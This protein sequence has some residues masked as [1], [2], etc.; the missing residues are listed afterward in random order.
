[1]GRYQF[2][3]LIGWFWVYSHKQRH[4]KEQLF[5]QNWAGQGQLRRWLERHRYRLIGRFFLW[6]WGCF[7]W[8]NWTNWGVWSCL[9]RSLTIRVRFYWFFWQF[10]RRVLWWRFFFRI[11]FGVCLWVGSCDSVTVCTDRDRVFFLTIVTEIVLC[12]GWVFWGWYRVIVTLR[13]RCRPVCYFPR[14]VFCIVVCFS[15]FRGFRMVW[16]SKCSS[17]I[18]YWCLGLGRLFT[19]LMRWQG[20]RILAL[21]SSLCPVSSRL[22]I[23]PTLLSTSPN[24]THSPPSLAHNSALPCF[25]TL[26]PLSVTTLPVAHCYDPSIGY[27]LVVLVSWSHTH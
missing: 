23:F 8:W 13:F 15:R 14:V 21:F 9:R 12:R 20:C 25:S 10:I 11:G 4:L 24:I 5:R 2:F 26:S 18:C 17:G 16:P 22:L 3:R 19:L 6:E 7:I 27:I 1:M